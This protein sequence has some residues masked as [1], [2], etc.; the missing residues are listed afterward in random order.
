MFFDLRFKYF[1]WPTLD[2]CDK[3]LSLLA[4]SMIKKANNDET[5]TLN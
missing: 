5:F 4:I 2:E 3:C 1:N